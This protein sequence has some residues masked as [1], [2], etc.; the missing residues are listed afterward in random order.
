MAKLS[1]DKSEIGSGTATSMAPE[2]TWN[3]MR[4][5]RLA[6][7]FEEPTMLTKLEDAELR[8]LQSQMMLDNWVMLGSGET[9]ES[10]LQ[11]IGRELR[12]LADLVDQHED[13]SERASLVIADWVLFRAKTRMRCN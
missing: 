11:S 13:L 2:M 9:P 6:V 10:T 4:P 5:P 7:R 8:L 3:E 12:S 1:T